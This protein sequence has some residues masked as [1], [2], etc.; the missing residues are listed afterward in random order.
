MLVNFAAHLKGK[1]LP[2]PYNSGFRHIDLVSP[3]RTGLQANRLPPS[4]LVPILDNHRAPMPPRL[5]I[6]CSITV[7][8][9]LACA[10]AVAQVPTRDQ[11]DESQDI[12]LSDDPAAIIAYV[13][14]APILLGDLTPKVEARIQEVLAKAGQEV[15]KEQL[16][17]ARLNL[18][19]GLLSQSIQQKM[20]RESFLID[21]VGTAGADKR[22]EADGKLTARARQMFFESE[23]PQ[24]KEQ[25][26]VEDRTKLDA[27]LREKGSSLAARQRDFVDAMLGHLYIRSK[28]DR[29]PN[30]SI[31]EIAEYYYANRVEFERPTQARWEQLTVKLSNYSSSAE[32]KKSLE[33]MGRDAYFGGNMQAV[34]RNKSE[35]P[36]AS[37]GG[38]HDWTPQGSLASDPLDQ[39]IF[40]IPLNQLSEIIK[41]NNAMHIIR[42]LE[43]TPAGVVSL[44]E[45]QDDIRSKIRKEK[46][47]TSQSEVLQQMRERIPVW[48]LFPKDVPGAKPLPEIYAS[49]HR[50]STIR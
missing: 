37:K 16:H 15:P 14:Q 6:M 43:R 11:I 18:L 10:P 35:E 1:F 44:S 42:V 32:A 8:T 17:F 39:Q 48:T 50:A 9:V 21:Q 26:K 25:Y 4:S 47:A 7:C 24:L 45:V 29:D 30:V 12:H 22:K 49:R 23:L 41:D 5:S 34:A 3:A 19:R 46:I 20:M 38:L 40:S 31:S 33:D 28:V 27:L 13:G 36:L 2:S